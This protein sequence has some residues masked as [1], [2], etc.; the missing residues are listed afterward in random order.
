MF[1]NGPEASSSA[2][3]Q[4]NRIVIRTQH[5]TYIAQLLIAGNARDGGF[6]KKPH[7]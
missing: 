7:E 6:N 5:V 1:L 2:P 4:T 3:Q